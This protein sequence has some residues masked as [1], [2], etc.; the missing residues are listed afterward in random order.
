[1]QNFEVGDDVWVK[2]KVIEPCDSLI[3]VTPSGNDN[4][5]WA[6]R[7][8]CRPV[9]PPLLKEFATTEPGSVPRQY[10]EPVQADLSNGPIECE[11]RE[12]EE[13]DWRTG[14]LSEVAVGEYRFLILDGEDS[15]Y[16]EEC[17]IETANSPEIP[18][19]SSGATGS[20]CVAERQ[21]PVRD[22]AFPSEIQ[23]VWVEEAVQVGDKV[24]FI[25]PGHRWDGVRGYIAS[26]SPER[27]R[28]YEFRTNCGKFMT[29]CDLTNLEHIDL[30]NAQLKTPNKSN[31]P[32]IL[33]SSAN[34]MQEA[35]EA[36]IGKRYGWNK[37]Y[38][39]RNE[40]RYF[41]SNVELLW[42][43]WQ[44]GVQWA[45]MPSNG[46]LDGEDLMYCGL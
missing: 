18:N 5:F 46:S 2:C 25:K 32:K 14:L 3:K 20:P 22:E 23:G 40:Y 42:L 34:T 7:G 6:G 4:W 11:Y 36:D 19:S 8:Q 37:A 29:Y 10:R 30:T 1:M 16:W 28:P 31:A 26:V 43:A 13:S 12:S 24:R 17:R 41:D 9:E 27:K 35:F 21:K 33:D 39:A 45:G 15:G 44:G 38:F